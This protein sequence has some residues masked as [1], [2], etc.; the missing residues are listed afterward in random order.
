MDEPIETFRVLTRPG[1]DA[2]SEDALEVFASLLGGDPTTSSVVL[3]PGTDRGSHRH[4]AAVAA[5]VVSGSVTFVFGA[6]GTGR[7]ELAPGDYVWIAAGV[8]HDEETSDG[9][10]LL[11]AQLEP[12]DTLVVG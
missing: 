8:V 5:G 12:F 7:V 11:V 3:P 9:V 2:E 4:T 1:A 6:D 10:E